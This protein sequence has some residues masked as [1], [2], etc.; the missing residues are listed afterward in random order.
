MARYIPTEQE[1][2][3]NTTQLR[4]FKNRLLSWRDAL[5]DGSR[6]ISAEL[7]ELDQKHPDLVDL[8]SHQAEKSR[9]LAERARQTRLIDQ[10][11]HALRRIEQGNY[12]Y[13]E[14][15]GEE[16]GLGRLLVMPLANLSVEAQEQL[17][18]ELN[19]LH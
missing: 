14:A 10:I 9:R 3:M 5:L 13:C 7:Q 19:R 12:G 18:R 6:G 8:G 11:E 16:I 4:Y 17:E 15:T 2:Y 1:E